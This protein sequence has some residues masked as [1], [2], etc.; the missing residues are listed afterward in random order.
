MTDMFLNAAS[1][2][3]TLLSEIGIEEN[4]IAS[5][6]AL[7]S[8]KKSEIKLPT[9]IKKPYAYIGG[10]I[11]QELIVKKLKELREKIS[12]GASRLDLSNE[13]IQNRLMYFQSEAFIENFLDKLP[14]RDKINITVAK[15]SYTTFFNNLFNVA[16]SGW[17]DEKLSRV[18]N[19]SQC[20]RALGIAP[21]VKMSYL[22]SL[23]NTMCY[24]CGRKILPENSGQ[25]T[26]EC[27]HILPILTALSH[28]WLIK[29]SA[30][31][32]TQEELRMLK[33]E[34]D[35]SHRCCNQLKS[36]YDFI[37]FDKATNLYKVNESLIKDFLVLVS[38]N[39]SYDCPSVNSKGKISAEQY[40]KVNE[41]TQP[42][43]NE[44]NKN[45][46]EFDSIDEYIVL[47]KFKILS[48]L[49][50]DDFLNAIVGQGEITEIPKT[51]KEIREEKK[52]ALELQERENFERAQQ[53]KLRQK[54]AREYRANVRIDIIPGSPMNNLLD[55]TQ[56]GGNLQIEQYGGTK[57]EEEEKEDILWQNF[58][59]NFSEKYP[60][61]YKR[62]QLEKERDYYVEINK[63]EGK[64]ENE[65]ENVVISSEKWEIPKDALL[66]ANPENILTNPKFNPNNSEFED[67]LNK[68]FVSEPI[69]DQSSAPQETVFSFMNQD[70]EEEAK[71]DL[72]DAKRRKLESENKPNNLSTVFAME[73][74]PGHGGKKSKKQTRKYVEKT[75]KR[76]KRKRNGRYG[77]NG[78]N[79]GNGSKSNKSTT[80]SKTRKYHKKRLS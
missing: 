19:Q 59:S 48:A 13:A 44:I 32:Y 25:S 20:R 58:E 12:T 79:G 71:P 61:E 40:K 55:R 36:N 38:A 47:T 78:R 51:A 49:S 50:S 63:I 18:D 5:F 29:G 34:Y 7:I 31:D 76:T 42:L 26:M 62:F 52:R 46:S 14:V 69:L 68:L 16:Y 72:Q 67:I 6:N 60:D 30:N 27:E 80:K 4:T 10:I 74:E 28:W 33:M 77:G 37:F 2:P 75:N 56:G 65:L 8:S 39:T 21:S 43:V 53:E 57:E 15:S 41:K 1:G 54:M 22:Q 17:R 24:L 11:I 45:L 35:W 23:G 73:V 64:Q 66:I 3:G 9:K 70:R